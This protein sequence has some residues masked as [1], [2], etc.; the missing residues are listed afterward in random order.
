MIPKFRSFAF[1]M[2]SD[3]G[4]N[5][6]IAKDVAGKNWRKVINNDGL[7]AK[8]AKRGQMKL[9]KGQHHLKVEYFNAKGKAGV[10]LKWAPGRR[11]VLLNQR[12][13]RY[14]PESG[15]KEEVFYV[16]GIKKLYDKKSP[17]GALLNGKKAT[18]ERTVRRLFYTNTKATW[19]RF[20]QNDNFA[21]RWSGL[22]KIRA[23]GLYRFQLVSDDG[24]RLWISNV[25][26]ARRNL[27]VN[28]D[29]L[30]GLRRVQGSLNIPR[31]VSGYPVVVEYF[32]SKGHAGMA[33]FYMGRDTGNKMILVGSRSGAV[34]VPNYYNVRTPKKFIRRVKPRFGRGRFR[35]ALRR[36]RGRFARRFRRRR[37]R[38][39][40][41]R[42]RRGR[43][44]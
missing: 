30:H 13:L 32:E 39:R 8:R 26:R 31:R 25:P 19:T 21:A 11:F 12:Y 44:R 35:R 34:Q 38:G 29:G 17:N 37:G 3:D 14:K 40:R 5:L 15:F 20:K 16:G 9:A 1:E 36:G 18:N 33:F 43:Y 24:S 10:V 4:S 2:T 22:L 6:Y 42:K 7:H 27:I 23:S 41:S 28:N